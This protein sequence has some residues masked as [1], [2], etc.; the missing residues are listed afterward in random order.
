MEL[1][2]IIEVTWPFYWNQRIPIPIGPLMPSVIPEMN[3]TYI[4]VNLYE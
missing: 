3:A 4:G 1:I 2:F